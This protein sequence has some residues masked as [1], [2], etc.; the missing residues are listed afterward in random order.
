MMMVVRPRMSFS[1]ACL[2]QALGFRVQRTGRLVEQQ[3]GR[4]LENGPRQR[5][6]LALTARQPRAALAQEGVVALRQLAQ[7]LIGGRGHR[8]GLDLGVARR[9]P[10]VADVLARA[11]AEQ[12]RLLRHQA[13]LRANV[14]RPQIRKPLVVDQHPAGI[15][16]V[17]A[18]QQLKRGALAGPGGTHE[19]DGFARARPRG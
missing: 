7:K 17:E 15:G 14:L 1:S 11:G 2:H 5:D 3:D 13:D 19:G 4:I 12:H 6:P 10:A 8:G 16:I 18:Q 9:R